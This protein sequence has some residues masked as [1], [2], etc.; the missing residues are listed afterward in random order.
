MKDMGDRADMVLGLD[1][2][3]KSVG[4]ALAE[5]GD[6]NGRLIKTGVR[7]FDAAVEG[8][9]E[10]GRAESRN[11]DRREARARRR[12]TERRARRQCKLLH[13][14]QRAGLLP[15]GTASEVIPPLDRELLAKHQANQ[16]PED[17]TH[18]RLPHVLPYWLR[19]RALDAKLEL[20]ELGRALYHLGQRRG[21][22]SNRK[23]PRREDEDDGQ[24]KQAITDL[25]GF[26]N[27]A[28]ARTLGEYF[29]Q[30]DPQ[31]ERI[32]SRWT[33]RE[34]YEAEFD[35]IWAAQQPHHPD[36]LTDRRRQ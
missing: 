27:E 17:P 34:M 1:I 20:G 4:W 31:E 9:F 18:N 21:F 6:G 24:V 36:V 33:G 29:A 8:A 32:R 19:A 3:S 11:K 13:Q 28:G 16:S 15:N 23:A 25:S 5:V 26:M 30:L 22:K 14:L 35:A 10:T 7:V 2:G 12:Q